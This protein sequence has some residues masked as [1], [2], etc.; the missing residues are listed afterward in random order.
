VPCIA[1]PARRRVLTSSLGAQQPGTQFPGASAARTSRPPA[2]TPGA[3][4][5][6]EQKLTHVRMTREAAAIQADGGE[7]GEDAGARALSGPAGD[8]RTA[9]DAGRVASYG[10]ASSGP[11]DANGYAPLSP[12]RVCQLHPLHRSARRLTVGCASPGCVLEGDPALLHAAAVDRRHGAGHSRLVR[13]LCCARIRVAGKRAR[14]RHA[15][16]TPAPSLTPL[17][18]DYVSARQL[19][20]QRRRWRA[21][22]GSLCGGM[23]TLLS[24]FRLAASRR[25]AR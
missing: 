5:R 17:R 23:S 21:P 13:R 20:R 11:S 8:M 22:R 18:S 10:A 14:Q 3:D 16:A 9:R 7:G 1:A 6:R 24:R 19:H 4:S 12:S 2:R 25:W 15:S